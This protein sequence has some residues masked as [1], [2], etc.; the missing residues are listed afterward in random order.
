[1]REDILAGKYEMPA[2]ASSSLRRVITALLHTDHTKRP[3]MTE[4]MRDFEWVREANEEIKPIALAC[5]EGDDD[6]DEMD[7]YDEITP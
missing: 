3:S 5:G 4:L 6:D 7:E 2:S 1:M